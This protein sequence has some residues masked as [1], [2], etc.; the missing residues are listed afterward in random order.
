[1]PEHRAGRRP[2]DAVV[3]VEVVV[4]RLDPVEV[5]RLLMRSSRVRIVAQIRRRWPKVRILVRADSGFARD[6]LMAWCEASGVHFLF[7]LAQK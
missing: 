2:C 3:R 6:E 7:G 5:R 4:P 1:M